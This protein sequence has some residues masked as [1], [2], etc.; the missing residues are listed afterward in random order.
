VSWPRGRPVVCLVTDRRR[1]PAPSL[2]ALLDRIAIAVRA[3]IDVVQLRERDLPDRAL[4][5]LARDAVALTRPSGV[6][7]VVNDRVDI[8]RAAEADGV[9]LPG[10][11]VGASRV[12]AEVPPDFIIGRSVH[13]A[14]DAEDVARQG[15]C[16]YLVFGTVY[17]SES[18]PADHPVAGAS[19]L[20]DVC[21][22]VALPV[23]A[24]GGI[25]ASNAR[26]VAAAGAAGVAAI[27]AFLID[28]EAALT[29]RVRAMHDAFDRR[30]PVI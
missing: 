22:R 24:I 26:A 11:G 18:K 25:D 8:A 20:A 4:V 5:A 23:L 6:L 2:S 30:S 10:D 16:D 1:L 12:R 27:G 29:K 7:L 15:G 21:A 13:S 9:H 17:R 3:G 28:D 14:P 19:I